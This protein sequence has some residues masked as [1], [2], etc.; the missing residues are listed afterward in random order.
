VTG[1]PGLTGRLDWAVSGR[2]QPD[3][4]TAWTRTPP[5]PWRPIEGGT[6]AR[7]LWQDPPPQPPPDIDAM[8]ARLAATPKADRIAAAIRYARRRLGIGDP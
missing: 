1:R 6:G 7:G 3:D 4:Q 8:R 5:G 2:W